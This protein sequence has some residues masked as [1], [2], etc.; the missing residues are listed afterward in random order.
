MATLKLKIFH[1]VFLIVTILIVSGC[2]TMEQFSKKYEGYTVVSRE[3]RPVTQDV[4]V[5]ILSCVRPNGAVR[6]EVESVGSYPDAGV[7]SCTISCDVKHGDSWSKRQTGTKKETYYQPILRL[8]SP[9]GQMVEE[10]VTASIFNEVREGQVF[11]TT[12]S[13]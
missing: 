1:V 11:S 3:S 6:C 7:N 13:K 12:K 10:K 9:T 2:A 8:K 4:P 5:W